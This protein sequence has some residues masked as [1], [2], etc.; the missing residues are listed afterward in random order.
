MRS[1]VVVHCA[2]DLHVIGVAV[3]LGYIPGALGDYIGHYMPA[4]T[5]KAVSDN[6]KV[7]VHCTLPFWA[8]P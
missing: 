3:H 5:G 8:Q 4:V 6:F 2:S 7:A 1:A